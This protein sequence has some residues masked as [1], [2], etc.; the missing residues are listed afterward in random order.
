MVRTSLLISLNWRRNMSERGDRREC[1]CCGSHDTDRAH[2]EWLARTVEEV[3]ICNNCPV[4]F[5][6]T[7]GRMEHRVDGPDEF[8]P[9]DEFT[10]ASEL[11]D[12]DE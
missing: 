10:K 3:R 8:T 9:D 7:F 5:T 6:N 4:Q 1:P 11:G 12:D 2:T